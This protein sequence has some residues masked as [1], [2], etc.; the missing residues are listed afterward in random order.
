M[1]KW[2]KVVNEERID[3]GLAQRREGKGT[4]ITLGG[5]RRKF[6]ANN[7]SRLEHLPLISLLS[8]LS[9]ASCTTNC[10][11]PL[12][13]VIHDKFGI[14]EGLMVWTHHGV[15]KIGPLHFSVLQQN[16]LYMGS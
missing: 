2:S 7:K 13:K 15:V 1:I 11:A 9:N 4:L 6:Q 12:A 16:K 10:L 3:A 5:K 8:F 14:V